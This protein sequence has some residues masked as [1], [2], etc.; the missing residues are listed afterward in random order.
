M[1]HRCEYSRISIPN[2]PDYI[3][4]VC[5]YAARIAGKIGFNPGD[6]N[7]IRDGLSITVRMVME[8][9]FEPGDRAMID[10]FFERIPEGLMITLRDKGLPFDFSEISPTEMLHGDTS[11]NGA[12]SLEQFVDE[13][14]RHN[15]GPDGREIV[16]I[17]GLP[18]KAITDY[19]AECDLIPYEISDIEQPHIEAVASIQVRPMEPSE[20]IEVARTVYKAYGFSYPFEHVYYPDRLV[21]MNADGQIHSVVA[22]TGD[23]RIAGHLALTYKD[24]HR[25]IA[26]MGQGV[27]KPEFR[28]MGCFSKMSDYLMRKAEVDGLM[29]IFGQA[30]TRHTYSQKVGSR[31]GLKDCALILGYVPATTTFKKMQGDSLHR[32]SVLMQF[33]YMA[34]PPTY[35]VY[36]PGHHRHIVER[37]YQNMGCHPELIDFKTEYNHLSEAAATIKTEIYVAL[38]YGRI[39]VYRYGQSILNDITLRLREL[40]LK[41]IEVINLYLDLTHPVTA[42]IAENI[43]TLGFFFA[44]ILPGGIQGSDALIY[45]YLNNVQ[46]DYEQIQV[47]SESS[48]SLLDYIRGHDPLQT[49]PLFQDG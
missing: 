6:I 32:G 37:L 30:V 3:D 2:D 29:G 36:P 33:K 31:M 24:R 7:D 47:D 9:G 44:G 45:Q 25:Y 39:T 22:V 19:Y 48:R 41:K 11:K 13:I 49:Q 42:A 18:S 14:R 28:S 35:T 20:A 17:K 5:D 27:V 21:K 1:I 10:L 16:L 46:I 12:G 4:L 40:C 26:E 15:L 38:G 34:Q 23:G 8:Y 43:E